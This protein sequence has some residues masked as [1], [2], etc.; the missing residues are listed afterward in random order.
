M[1]KCLGQE[2]NRKWRHPATLNPPGAYYTEY[3]LALIRLMDKEGIQLDPALKTPSAIFFPIFH[4]SI[5]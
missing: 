5:D 3:Q 1:F 2:R 4:Q